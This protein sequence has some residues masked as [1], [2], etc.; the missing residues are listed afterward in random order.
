MSAV[1]A[2]LSA[3]KELGDQSCWVRK[4]GPAAKFISTRTWAP[5]H[6]SLF[7]LSP[8]FKPRLGVLLTALSTVKQ[9]HTE[10]LLPFCNKLGRFPVLHSSFTPG[11]GRTM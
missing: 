2:Q 11:L 9:K 4:A 5:C 1:M 8:G 3:Q 6:M 10:M 7:L